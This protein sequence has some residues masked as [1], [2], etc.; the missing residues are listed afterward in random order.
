MRRLL[1]QVRHG[2]VRRVSRLHVERMF[3][4]SLADK[5]LKWSWLILA[6]IYKIENDIN[7]K[8]Y[9]GKT[10][11]TIQKR[12]Q[13]HCYEASRENKKHRPLYAAMNKYGLEHFHVSLVEETDIPEER[14]RYWIEFFNSF[15][16]GYNATL[17][18][19][20]KPY[21]DYN[22]VISTYKQLKN[23]KETAA[24]LNISADTV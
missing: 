10:Y 2:A 4:Q 23:Q 3:K 15:K 13:E 16:Y 5:I 1:V 6:Y 18:G 19:D 20:G 24:Q 8:I 7:H 17:G 9:I 14:E 21:V 22:L 12:F 11:K